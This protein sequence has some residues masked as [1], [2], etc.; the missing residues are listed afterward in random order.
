MTEIVEVADEMVNRTIAIAMFRYQRT[1][2]VPLRTCHHVSPL[3]LG[4]YEVQQEAAYLQE[5]AYLPFPSGKIVFFPW[6]RPHTG[7]DWV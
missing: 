7:Y 3:Y 4:L 2:I 5:E 6:Y 1:P